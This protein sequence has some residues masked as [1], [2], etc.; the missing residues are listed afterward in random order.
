[1]QNVNLIFAL[2]TAIEN[3]L[4]KITIRA[5]FCIWCII[6]GFKSRKKDSG[7]VLSL[8]K[9]YQLA[10]FVIEVEQSHRLDD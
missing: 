5:G 6:S 4:S 1:M 10:S 9:E 3:C 7:I 2:E 8:T